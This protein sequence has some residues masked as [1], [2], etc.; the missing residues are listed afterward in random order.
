MNHLGEEGYLRLAKVV[1][2]TTRGLREGIESIPG[3]HIWG[4]P[5]MSV[6][7]FGSQAFDIFAVA[8]V[9]DDH[10]WHLDRQHGPDAL[11]LMVSPAHADV[12]G[13][14][15]ADLRAAALDHG[16]SKGVEARYS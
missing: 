3:L 5:V 10:G 7:C 11:H 15:L 6:L 9:M 14:F 2:D 16:T 12:A 8:D 1:C 13:T 4:D